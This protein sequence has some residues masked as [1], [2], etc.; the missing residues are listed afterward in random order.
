MFS[1]ID[2]EKKSNPI[3]QG[4]C[5]INSP[6]IAQLTSSGRG[7]FLIPQGVSLVD[8]PGVLAAGLTDDFLRDHAII[9]S[10]KRTKGPQLFLSLSGVYGTY[11]EAETQILNVV[12]RA[13]IANLDMFLKSPQNVDNF[14]AA[15]SA[16]LGMGEEEMSAH[17]QA[18]IVLL[19][20]DTLRLNNGNELPFTLVSEVIDSKSYSTVPI[21]ATEV[22]AATPAAA[23]TQA[24]Q[25]AKAGLLIDFDADI[26]AVPS[27]I[28]AQTMHAKREQTR[29]L[30]DGTVREQG[31]GLGQNYEASVS[32]RDAFFTSV[33]AQSKVFTEQVR[34]KLDEFIQSFAAEHASCTSSDTKAIQ[35]KISQIKKTFIL[36]SGF[37]SDGEQN[38]SIICGLENYLTSNLYN[39]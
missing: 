39:L 19:R 33:F 3:I 38:A 8:K 31:C 6:V 14:F 23:R 10:A 25:G 27:S 18:S 24:P 22:V 34:P 15:N 37:A 35:D 17:V 5:A 12:G 11:D 26:P 32:G 30:I 7:R 4:L 13:A 36:N 1:F 21:H 29:A 20:E 28:P 9:L 2:Y 16:I